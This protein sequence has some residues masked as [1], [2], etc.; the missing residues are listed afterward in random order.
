MV[1]GYFGWFAG[2][3]ADLWVVSSFTANGRKAG[4][5]IFHL[6]KTKVFHLRSPFYFFEHS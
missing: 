6:I 4:S 2:G 5:A 1:C 3:L